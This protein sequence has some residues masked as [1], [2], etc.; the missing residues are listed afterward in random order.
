MKKIPHL[1]SSILVALLATSALHVQSQD[2][3]GKEAE[4]LALF[5]EAIQ[6]L[7]KAKL[8][9]VLDERRLLQDLDIEAIPETD[10][11]LDEARDRLKELQ[12]QGVIKSRREMQTFAVEP[13]DSPVIS[14]GKPGPHKIQ[15]IGAGF[16]PDILNKDVID[17]VVTVTNDESFVMARRLA[18]EEGIPAGISTGANVT[19]AIAVAKRPGMAGKR[20]V[21]VAPSPTERY[22]STALAETVRAEVAELPVA[23]LPS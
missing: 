14:G 7:E 6:F 23:E 8:S 15:G 10:Q 16:I 22:L 12:E 4:D 21:A 18:A 9:D 13:A 11:I 5:R 19:A 2:P 1:P 20:I 17:D 3:D